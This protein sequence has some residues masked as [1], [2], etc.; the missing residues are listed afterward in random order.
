M[1]GALLSSV[2]KALPILLL[3]ALVIPS[4]RAAEEEEPEYDMEAR[5]QS[6]VNMTRHIEQ[7]EQRLEQLRQDGKRLEDRIE[8]QAD[9]LV[10]MLSEIKDSEQSKYRVSQIKMRAI[11]GLRRWIETYQQRRSRILETLR[12][13]SEKLPADQLQKDID[14]FDKRIEKRIAQIMDL[15][16]SM[17]DHQDVKKYERDGGH[18]YS[19]YY[20]ENS[21]ISEEWKQNRR[22]STMAD[23]TRRELIKAV[24]DSIRRLESRRAGIEDKFNNRKIPDGERAVLAEELGR[25]DASLERRHTDLSDLVKPQGAASGQAV[26]RNKAHDIQHLIEDASKDLSQ[27][28]FRLLRMYDEYVE[29]RNQIFALQ[30]NLQAR[31]EWLEKHDK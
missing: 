21:R 26:G 24:E 30:E 9:G 18:Y 1:G 4:L 19:G 14:E 8:S 13:H 6:V 5:R 25:I 10:K 27:D 7:R 11:D 22:Q 16:A 3:T 15:S 28:I 12:H 31:K 2:M 17:G 23:K 29:E 20:Y